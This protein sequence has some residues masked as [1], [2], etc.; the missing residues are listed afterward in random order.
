MFCI[1]SLAPVIA[2]LFSAALMVRLLLC[3]TPAAAPSPLLNPRVFV[4]SVPQVS[5]VVYSTR[6][7]YPEENEEVVSSALQRARAEVERGGEA[8]AAGFRSAPAP[9]ALS[10][11][12]TASLPA[13][14]S[15]LVPPD[16]LL[17]E[18]QRTSGC[19][20]RRCRE[21]IIKGA[22]LCSKRCQTASACHGFFC[23]PEHRFVC[24]LKFSAPVDRASLWSR[25]DRCW[26]SLRQL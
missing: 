1:C 10:A 8:K 5:A 3:V 18:P 21:S 23:L 9:A 22:S 15:P 24:G 20:R 4:R 17:S 26:Q 6:S 25:R 13:C 12:F 11:S 16:G 19:S 2:S 14:Q 7:L